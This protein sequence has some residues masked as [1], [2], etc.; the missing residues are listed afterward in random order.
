MPCDRITQLTLN[1]QTR[2]FRLAQRDHGLTLK[3]I[4]IDSGIN[5]ET[6]R[7]YAGNKEAQAVMSL[8]SFIKLMGVIPDDLL[9]QL[10]GPGDR[11]L[12]KDDDEDTE[13]DDLADHGD[14]VARLVR[15]ARHPSSPGGTEIIAIEEEAI[16]RAANG[17]GR[18]RAKL[19]IVA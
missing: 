2:V 6:I 9:S 10:L 8:P 3:S 19:R 17:Y 15:Q 16:K 5:Y 12:E 11:H 7:S 13:Y 18:K 4:S 1:A 14:N